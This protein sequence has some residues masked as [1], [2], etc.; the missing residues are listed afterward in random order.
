MNKLAFL[1][2]ISSGLMAACGPDKQPEEQAQ[3][4]QPKIS[5]PV[6]ELTAISFNREDTLL[7]YEAS[8]TY[9]GIQGDQV[10]N[11]IMQQVLKDAIGRFEEFIKDFEGA[12]RNLESKYEVVQLSDTVVSIRQ[13]FEWFVPGTSIPLY[14][15]QSIN[16]APT[17]KQVIELSAFFPP[18]KDY[19]TVL[20]KLLRAKIEKLYQLDMEVRN[21]DLD[22][23][24][25]GP[26]Y[27]EFYKVLYPELMEPEPKAFRVGFSEL[28]K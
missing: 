23:F 28:K 3:A 7:S 4:W 14:D 1:L 24:T 10:F 2:L 22:G 27:L 13:V 25:I 6:P 8:I 11:A 15:I 12:G 16:Y 5:G 19:H 9:P 20:R 21:D 26:D 18:G 17:P